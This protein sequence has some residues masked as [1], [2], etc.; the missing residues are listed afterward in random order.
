MSCVEMEKHMCPI[1]GTEHETGSILLDRR[2]KDIK[3]GLTG[4]SLCTEHLKLHEND[5]VAFISSTYSGSNGVLSMRGAIPNGDVMHMPRTIA[6]QLLVDV[7]EDDISKPFMY[8]SV[9]A[10][11]AIKKI[12]SNSSE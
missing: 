11:E 10:F 6:K 4:I 8:I 3:S 9:E 2:L 5:Y 12:M 1:C 7:S